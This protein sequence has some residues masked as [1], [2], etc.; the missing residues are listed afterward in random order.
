MYLPFSFCVSTSLFPPS[1]LQFCW[2]LCIINISC[3]MWLFW[4]VWACVC[5]L[6][7]L[8]VCVCVW[9]HTHI[10]V[11][12][13]VCVIVS[14]CLCACAA[15]SN[16][17]LTAVGQSQFGCDLSVCLLLNIQPLLLFHAPPFLWVY[18]LFS[19]SLSLCAVHLFLP[20]PLALH[21]PLSLCFI[22]SHFSVF[23]FSIFFGSFSGGKKEKKWQNK[24]SQ[25]SIDK[26]SLYG[27][28]CLLFFKRKSLN[29]FFS[30]LLKLTAVQGEILEYKQ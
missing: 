10:C 25:K 8:C 28:A 23:T 9:D 4:I 5:A 12:K 3:V 27:N 29:S 22:P 11:C 19:C 30:V 21:P 20:T 13:R 15:V 1:Y 2:L 17:A 18:N 7:S 6:V 26:C 24:R 16:S 14:V